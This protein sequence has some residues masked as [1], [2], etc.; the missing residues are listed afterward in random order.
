MRSFAMGVDPS[1]TGTGLAAWGPAD[2]WAT[3]TIVTKGTNVDTEDRTHLRL[4][5]ITGKVLQFAY[6]V[7]AEV[8]VIE[9]PTFSSNT[10]HARDRAGLFWLMYDA[11]VAAEYRVAVVKANT[12]I[13][14]ALGKGAGS[15]DAVLARTIRMYPEAEIRN[16][17]EADAVLLAAMGARWADRPCDSDAAH[18]LDAVRRVAWPARL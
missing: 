5:N 14:Y 4:R 9:S 10:G 8:V 7:G 1:L 15:K 17:N 2:G 11:L 16:N 6:T 3:R 13:R 18:R 12:R